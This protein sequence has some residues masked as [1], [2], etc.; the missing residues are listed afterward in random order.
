MPLDFLESL[1]RSS[2]TTIESLS[3]QSGVGVIDLRPYLCEGGVCPTHRKDGMA[4]YADPAH[5]SVQASVELTPQ[6]LEAVQRV[7]Q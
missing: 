3:D 6:F 5:I 1:Q 7:S 2:R 4:L